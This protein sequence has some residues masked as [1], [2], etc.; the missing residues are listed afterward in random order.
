PEPTPLQRRSP[1]ILW[2]RSARGLFRPSMAC[3]ALGLLPC[4]ACRERAPLSAIH[5]LR[6]TWTPVHRRRRSRRLRRRHPLRKPLAVRRLVL[7]VPAGSRTSDLPITFLL[8]F[9]N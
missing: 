5:G 2:E 3:E 8:I 4:A 7:L 1:L 6:G 9:H